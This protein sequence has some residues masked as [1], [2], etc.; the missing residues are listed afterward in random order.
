MESSAKPGRP[1]LGVSVLAERQGSVVLVRRGKPPFEGVWSLPG[2]TVEFGESLA[3]AAVREM[4]EETG[5][6]VSVGPVQTAL[7]VMSQTND[8]EVASHHVLVVFRATVL[9][10]TLVAGDDAAD[11][12]WVSIGDLDDRPMT[13]GTAELIKTL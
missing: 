1:V 7:D 3:E 4:R 6:T 8:G 5:L 10:G 2:G 13:P 9:G 12:E 11:G